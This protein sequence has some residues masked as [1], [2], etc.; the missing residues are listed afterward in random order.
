MSSKN[1]IPLFVRLYLKLRRLIIPFELIEKYV[2]KNGTVVDIGCGYGIFANYLALKS[3]NRNVV[4]IDLIQKRISI[5]KKIYGQSTNLNFFC[6][7]ITDTQLPKA[8]VITAIDV[9]HHIPSHDLQ[10]KLLKSCYSVL[11]EGGKLILKDLDK[12]PKWKYL[13]NYI[14]DYLMTRGDPVLYQDESSIKNLLKNSGFKIEKTI[15]IQNYP[16]SHILFLAQKIS[17]N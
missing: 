7:N 5:A 14:H 9:L 6:S 8:D 16:Y 13:F 12:K 17:N 15:K 10:N 11:K 1:K 2:P 4:G 3:T